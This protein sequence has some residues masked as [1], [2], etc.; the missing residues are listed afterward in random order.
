MII[1]LAFHYLSGG[2][3]PFHHILN[4][5][6]LAMMKSVHQEKS[7]L[8]DVHDGNPCMGRTGQEELVLIIPQSGWL[9]SKHSTMCKLFCDP[10]IEISMPNSSHYHI[11]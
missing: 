8:R 3:S 10:R 4:P 6:I 5:Q 11:S 1:Y 7:M 9:L 2:W